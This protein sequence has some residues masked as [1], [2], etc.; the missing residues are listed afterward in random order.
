MQMIVGNN[1]V[2][3]DSNSR[4]KERRDTPSLTDEEDSRKLALG[5]LAGEYIIIQ[6]L[7]AVLSHGKVAKMYSFLI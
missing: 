2:I 4:L 5:Y 1:G 3:E 7:I 6:Q